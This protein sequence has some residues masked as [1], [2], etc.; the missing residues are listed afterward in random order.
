MVGETAPRCR[1]RRMPMEMMSWSQTTTTRKKTAQRQAKAC[2]NT[3]P[4][5]TKTTSQPRW[6]LVS[7]NSRPALI[8]V[9]LPNPSLSR[10]H[11]VPVANPAEAS[12]NARNHPLQ[13]SSIRLKDPHPIHPRPPLSN[14]PPTQNLALCPAGTRLPPR[15]QVHLCL[16]HA[17][18]QAIAR[19]AAYNTPRVH[20]RSTPT[21]LPSPRR[22]RRDA[23]PEPQ[24]RAAAPPPAAFLLSQPT[25][26][27]P[28]ATSQPMPPPPQRSIR[29]SPPKTKPTPSTQ[30]RP[31]SRRRWQ[32]QQG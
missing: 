6:P 28:S 12:T 20:A 4:T 10:P 29:P 13:S 27:R 19:P 23:S 14:P 9:H 24:L 3:K 26:P 8:Q 1:D 25:S 17:Q 2:R 22:Q 7:A 32:W 11:P 15:L 30:C 18:L 21:P 16:R 5:T 31:A